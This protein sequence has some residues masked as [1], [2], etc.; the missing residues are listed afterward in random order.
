MNAI[1]DM[2]M[3]GIICKDCGSFIDGES[4]GYERNCGCII[5]EKSNDNKNSFTKQITNLFNSKN[6]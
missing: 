1:V 5:D 2:I 4:P 6:K 3:D